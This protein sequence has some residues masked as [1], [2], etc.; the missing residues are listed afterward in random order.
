MKYVEG[1]RCWLGL[2]FTGPLFGHNRKHH[3]TED[4]KFEEKKEQLFYFEVAGQGNFELSNPAGLRG[5]G[6][7]STPSSL[8]LSLS[9]EEGISRLSSPF[10]VK[11]NAPH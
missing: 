9:L 6:V 1:N 7:A 11:L 8:S 2:H 10:S 5:F 3:C 4:Y